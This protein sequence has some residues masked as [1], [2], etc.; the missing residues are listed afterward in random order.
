MSLEAS[1]FERNPPTL[2]K[3]RAAFSSGIFRLDDRLL[4][5][6][7]VSRLLDLAEAG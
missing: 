4:V 2:D 7:D 6:L 3:T 1:R 5:V